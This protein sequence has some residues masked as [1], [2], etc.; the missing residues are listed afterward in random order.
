MALAGP[1]RTNHSS[2]FPVGHR[3]S[4]TNLARY[5]DWLTVERLATSS[6]DKRSTYP[7]HGS[8]CQAAVASLSSGPGEI[9]PRS[10][11][12]QRLFSCG[13]FSHRL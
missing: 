7:I 10:R 1:Y 5:I 6:Y 12:F 8:K 13:E 11:E 3:V 9:D 2:V 4:R